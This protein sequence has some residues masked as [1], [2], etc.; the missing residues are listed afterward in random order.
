MVRKILN[1]FDMR[2]CL[3][4]FIA[5]MCGKKINFWKSRRAPMPH[6]WRHQCSPDTPIVMLT[7]ASLLI[8]SERRRTTVSVGA[9][10]PGLQCRYAAA[11]AFR[12]PSPT[13]RTAFPAQHLRPSGVFSCWP[14]GLELT[15]GFYPRSNEQHRLF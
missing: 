13:C 9:L 12:Q 14:D 8:V 5:S 11:S 15:A 2:D 10:H 6:S 1:T 4:T 3:H 7:W